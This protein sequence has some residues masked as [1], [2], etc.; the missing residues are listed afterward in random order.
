[1]RQITQL[2]RTIRSDIEMKWLKLSEI[3]ANL[4]DVTKVV[5]VGGERMVDGSKKRRF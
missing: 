1:M 5:V 2:S 3:G 4:G